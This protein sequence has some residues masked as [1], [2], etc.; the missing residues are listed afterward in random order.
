MPEASLQK[1]A[2]GSPQPLLCLEVNPPRGVHYDDILQRLENRVAGVDF[3]NVTDAALAKMRLA[4]FP[5]AAVLKRH[6]G[7]EPLVNFSCRDR[8]VIALQAELLGAWIMG[9]HAVVAL[10]GDAVTVGDSPDVKGVFEV[11]SI[12]LLHIIQSLNSGKDINGHELKGSPGFFPGVVVNPNA[13][14]PA[15]EL[16]RLARKKEAGARYALSQPVFDEE[17]S[18]SFFRETAAMGIP[19]F[20]GLLPLKNT[21]AARGAAAIPG[22]R[23]S[24]SLTEQLDQGERD[25]SS[26]SIDLCLRLAHLNREFVSGYHVVSG[27]SPRLGLELAGELAKY[28]KESG[29]SF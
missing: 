19:V 3:F 27:S 21:A 16:K 1:I 25:L 13:R 24:Q 2:G 12:G 14:N 26:V 9:L 5:F 28:I 23:L 8:N 4:A 11:N 22:I 17:S 29:G 7:I 15:A 6:F 20:M 18:G 10:T